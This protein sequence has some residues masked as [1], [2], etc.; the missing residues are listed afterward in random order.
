MAKLHPSSLTDDLHVVSLT[1]LTCSHP[2]DP[3]PHPVGQT[4]SRLH[5]SSTLLKGTFNS[6]NPLSAGEID[7]KRGLP[8]ND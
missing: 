2:S 6:R 1:G 4:E 8:I 3:T 7:G 5:M